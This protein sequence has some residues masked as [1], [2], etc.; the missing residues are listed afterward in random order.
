MG[1]IREKIIAAKRSKI[2]EVILPEPNRRDFDE[3][4]DSVRDGITV[5]FAERFTDVEKIVFNRENSSIH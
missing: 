5:H 3:L 1:G 2:S 4:P